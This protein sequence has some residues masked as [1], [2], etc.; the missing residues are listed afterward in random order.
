MN[1]NSLAW[2]ENSSKTLLETKVFSVESI[3]CT[4]PDGRVNGDYI[5]L[6][7]HDWVCVIPVLENDFLM[8]KQWRH[9]E[10]SISIE[11]PGGVIDDGETPEEAARRELLEETGFK[12]E[13]LIYLGS[14]NPNPAIMSNHMHFFAAEKLIPT[15]EQHLDNDE[16]L[17][18]MRVNQKEV[19]SKMGS[20]EYPHAL[21][22]AALLK[23]I[24]WKNTDK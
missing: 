23:Y 10:R 16:Y 6:N 9:G 18:Y 17:N 8:V 7:S 20:S 5:V 24:Q 3:N 2:T 12:S 22:C 1:E 15:G 21:M 4:A 14:V 19:M 11:F 13:K